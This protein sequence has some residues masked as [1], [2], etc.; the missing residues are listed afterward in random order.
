MSRH[1]ITLIAAFQKGNSFY[2]NLL[3]QLYSIFFK[4]RISLPTSNSLMIN[5]TAMED[6]RNKIQDRTQ[7]SSERLHTR[8]QDRNSM[9]NHPSSAGMLIFY[10]QRIISVKNIYLAQTRSFL[11]SFFLGFSTKYNIFK[12]VFFL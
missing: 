5:A 8:M 2:K 3:K 4:D 10:V 7:L 6:F 9:P 11:K 12:K 1:N